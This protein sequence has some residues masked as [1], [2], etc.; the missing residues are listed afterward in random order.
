MP[1]R[2]S[3]KN[4]TLGIHGDNGSLRPTSR[5]STKRLRTPLADIGKQSD[6]ALMG[7]PV[8]AFES[9]ETAFV[10]GSAPVTTTP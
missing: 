1:A 9:L 4:L 8:R 6:C 7:K 5:R 2:P 10:F 3:G